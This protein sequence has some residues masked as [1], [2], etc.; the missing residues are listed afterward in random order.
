M[1]CWICSALGVVR[2]EVEVLLVGRDRGLVVL[3]GL[4][5]VARTGGRRAGRPSRAASRSSK[6]PSW[7]R[8]EALHLGVRGA[9]ARFGLRAERLRRRRSSVSSC[10]NSLSWERAC[11]GGRPPRP[12][13]M[14]IV[15]LPAGVRDLP[16]V[17]RGQRAQGVGVL[18]LHRPVL[19]VR[20]D[21]DADL[22]LGLRRA[23]EVELRRGVV[24]LLGR[25]LAGVVERRRAGRGWRLKRSE[26]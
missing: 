13:S 1:R 24:R 25:G 12:R 21:G 11:S 18:R 5:R 23:G 14:A 16:A 17:E 3:S 6:T 26:M 9:R 19:L 7:R 22:P 8:R 20:G 10:R 4:G 15:G 2:L